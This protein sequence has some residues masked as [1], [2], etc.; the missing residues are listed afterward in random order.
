MAEEYLGIAHEQDLGVHGRSPVRDVVGHG[1]PER[2]LVQ[3]LPTLDE[4]ADVLLVFVT[5][6]WQLRLLVAVPG[7]R[8][9]E[10][11]EADRARSDRPQGRYDDATHTDVQRQVLGLGDVTVSASRAGDAVIR[12]RDVP[13]GLPAGGRALLPVRAVPRLDE[14]A[15][16]V[17]LEDHGALP[18]DG[19]GAGEC[20]GGLLAEVLVDL[21]DVPGLVVELLDFLLGLLVG[22]FALA[23]AFGHRIV[24]FCRH[25]VVLLVCREGAPVPGRDHSVCCKDSCS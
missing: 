9:H 4:V 18:R 20:G 25:R 7:L 6:T 2:I 17:H 11:Y 16:L 22:L 12:L 3:A 1:V 23:F 10:G 24:V 21:D 15:H 5:E 13:P 14:V 19:G 8:E